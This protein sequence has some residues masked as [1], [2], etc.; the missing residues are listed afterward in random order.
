MGAHHLG[1]LKSPKKL[2]AQCGQVERLTE[3]RKEKL[4]NAR[5]LAKKKEMLGNVV[6]E[7]WN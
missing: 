3:K 7:S 6:K 1:W 4:K 2:S 5:I